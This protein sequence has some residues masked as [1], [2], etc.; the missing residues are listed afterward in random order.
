MMAV[1]KDKNKGVFTWSAKQQNLK[2]SIKLKVAKN[3]PK[4]YTFT[5]KTKM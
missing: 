5:S 2:G 3:L 1:V 4:Y